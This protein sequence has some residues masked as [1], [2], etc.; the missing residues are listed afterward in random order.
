MYNMIPPLY[1]SRS[2]LY[3][4]LKPRIKKSPIGNLLSILVSETIKTFMLPLTF[5][6]RNLKLF[7]IELIYKCAKTNLFK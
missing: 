6:E 2:S 4:G 7:L 5:L 3:G 1:E